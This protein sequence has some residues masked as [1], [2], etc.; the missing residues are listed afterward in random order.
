M[1]V[2]L[3]NVK[4]PYVDSNNPPLGLCYIAA[5]LRRKADVDIK[6][7]DLGVEVI[8]NAI[9]IEKYITLF[10]PDIIGISTVTPT[11]NYAVELAQLIKQSVT[12]P[13][14]VG[15]P[16]VSA[17]PEESSQIGCFDTVVIGEGEIIF[18]QLC[19]KVETSISLPAIVRG[20]AIN[21]FDIMPFPAR[22]LVDL[23]KYN[24]HIGEHFG[25]SL[26]TSRSCPFKC[27]F[28]NKSVF[29]SNF[30]QHSA[31]R[32]Y[33]EIRHLRDEF[34]C[35][36]FYFLDDTFTHQPEI[37]EKLCQ[38]IIQ[39]NINIVWK[40]M[41]RV[42]RI[43]KSL[44]GLMKRAGCV[45]IVIGVETGDA[46]IMKKIRKGI[47]LEQVESVI[48]F[49]KELSLSTKTFFMIGFPWD[50]EETIRKTINFAVT[51]S[52]DSSQFALIAPFPGTQLCDILREM[53]ISVSRDWNDYLLKGDEVN[54][55]YSLPGLPREKL[56]EYVQ[57]AY[58]CFEKKQRL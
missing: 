41:T 25:T 13:I 5:W 46:E 56:K 52:P 22:D 36:A 19:Q 8:D 58:E 49:A 6:I 53:N 47:T 2:L 57:T 48:G 26:L 3:V 18:S 44:L 28:C 1:R 15:G 34:D 27:V 31:E 30:R 12:T 39:D 11:F 50:T 55:A 17:L 10:Q 54:Y 14:V 37:V 20:E 40:C 9:F 23:K 21:Q 7:A 33:A 38:I 32:I 24:F 4:N 51:L 16:H 42:D 43:N 35:H 29:G 45:E